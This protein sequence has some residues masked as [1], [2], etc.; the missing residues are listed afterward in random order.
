MKKD[1]MRT[2]EDFDRCAVRLKTIADQDR[3]HIVSVLLTGPKTVT[4]V[5][6]AVKISL[7]RVS[8]HL[9]I[10][11]D[12]QILLSR[13]Q[14]RYVIYWLNPQI[15]KSAAGLESLDLGDFRFSLFNEQA[16]RNGRFREG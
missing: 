16:M 3:L 15:T 7:A 8:H 9:L 4:E 6:Q 1:V 13:K 5:A 14:G 12:A 2:D 11:R 10:L